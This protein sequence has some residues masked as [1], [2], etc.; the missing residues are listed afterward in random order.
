MIVDLGVCIF[1][2]LVLTRRRPWSSLPMAIADIPDSML[3]AQ[4]VEVVMLFTFV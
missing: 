4:I 3:S 1:S 2:T